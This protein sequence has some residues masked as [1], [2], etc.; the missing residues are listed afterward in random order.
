M[1]EKRHVVFFDRQVERDMSVDEYALFFD[2][3]VEKQSGRPSS[4]P[5]AAGIA[6]SGGHVLLISS[7]NVS[8]STVSIYIGCTMRAGLIVPYS[9]LVFI[10]F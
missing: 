5:S 2:G 7:I 3:I 10:L 1:K 4:T 9:Y 6:N 8:M